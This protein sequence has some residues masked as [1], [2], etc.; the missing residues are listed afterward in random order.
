MINFLKKYGF[1]VWEKKR[2]YLNSVAWNKFPF[3]IG[4]REYNKAYFDIKDN[5]FYNLSY[6]YEKE[7]IKRYE[8]EKDTIAKEESPAKADPVIIPKIPKLKEGEEKITG[9][10]RLTSLLI[11]KVKDIEKT[12]REITKQ[13]KELIKHGMSQFYFNTKS[14]NIEEKIKSNEEYQKY[15][16]ESVVTFF[17]KKLESEKII[18]CFDDL[19]SFCWCGDFD[20]MTENVKNFITLQACNDNKVI[21]QRSE[22]QKRADRKYNE[23]VKGK[24]ANKKYRESEKG[25]ATRANYLKSE[26]GKQATNKAIKKYRES[27]QGQQSQKQAYNKYKDSKKGKEA[28]LRAV[29]AYR[30]RQ[31]AL[32][33]SQGLEEKANDNN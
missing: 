9:S 10:R 14:E 33:A 1:K 18:S 6:G 25:K 19:L 29:K 31:K 17:I 16:I 30:E 5:R 24:S 23:S 32:K 2:I 15:L 4:Q 7:I 11:E 22:A 21:T 8:A 3:A 26:Q 27:N 13:V 28:I 12:P 20:K